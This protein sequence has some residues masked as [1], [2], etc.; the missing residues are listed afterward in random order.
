MQL[1][2][3][4]SRCNKSVT[5]PADPEIMKDKIAEET[6]IIDAVKR[7]E[8]FGDE[9]KELEYLPEVVTFLRK[10]DEDGGAYFEVKALAKLCGPDEE[11]KRNKGGC[12]NRVRMLVDDIH[13]V[14]KARKKAQE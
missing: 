4:C 13:R 8:K 10:E 2:E 5:I 14:P 12:L 1:N 3:V 9:L 7:C 6:Y 11:K